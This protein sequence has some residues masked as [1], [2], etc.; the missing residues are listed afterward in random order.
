MS[1]ARVTP[2][3][4]LRTGIT[5]RPPRLLLANHQT[6]DQPFGPDSVHGL[7]R[8][9][10]LRRTRFP[11]VV[12][13]RVVAGDHQQTGVVAEVAVS[14][15][16]AGRIRRHEATDP[17]RERKLVDYTE[18]VHVEQT[19]VMLT[20]TPRERLRAA[21]AATTAAVPDVE[22]TADGRTHSVWVVADPELLRMVQ[23]ELASLTELYIADGHHRMA[24]ADQ[25]A[26]RRCG[27][28]PDAPAA[29][30]LG[31]LF[32]CDEMRIFGYPR[33]VPRPAG[34]ST[35]EVVSALAAAPGTAG[36]E[37]FP[38]AEGPHPV[39]GTAAVFLDRRWYRL[40]LDESHDGARSS[41]D[42]VRLD[43]GVLGPVFGGVGPTY[44]PGAYGLEALAGWCAEHETVGFLPYPPSVAD[45]MAVSD[46]GSV[47][48][49][50]STWFDPK[51]PQGLFVRELF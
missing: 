40:W 35:D 19:P 17:E 38:P 36:L 41:L 39:P 8:E 3:A 15:Y 18:T 12:V 20:H 45:V 44:P 2:E 9:G 33:S 37:E 16:R 21:L 48:P 30:T 4:A 46:T 43:E 14:D 31:A 6:A 13:Y 5:V 24:S 47:M 34:W 26:A 42:S 22:F 25:Y 23:G 49:P 32:P 11:V 10:T 27:L 28:G 50:K 7:L 1:T 29:Y 51:A